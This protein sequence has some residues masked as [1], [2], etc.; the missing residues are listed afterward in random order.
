MWNKL[1]HLS[2]VLY[3]FPP[4]A[5]VNGSVILLGQAFCV[6]YRDMVK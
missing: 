3:I 6:K 5:E 4:Q 2:L 1:R